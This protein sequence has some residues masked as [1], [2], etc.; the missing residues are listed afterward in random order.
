MTITTAPFPTLP[1]ADLERASKFYEHTLGFVPAMEQMSGGRFYEAGGGRI[2][3]YETD[4]VG[5]AENTAAAW[6][7]DDIESEVTRLTDAGV[8]FETFNTPGLEWDG[9]I[10]S[11]G[12]VRSAWFKDTEGNTLSIG[13][14]L[15]H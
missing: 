9:L 12:D 1:V 8:R 13:E 15:Y 6:L 11:I 2:L 10:A 4:A 14:M 3:L 7:V 5:T